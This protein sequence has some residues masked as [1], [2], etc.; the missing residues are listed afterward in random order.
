MR[1]RRAA[2]MALVAGCATGM[3]T[4][5]ED[6]LRRAAGPL[7]AAY[8]FI[9]EAPSPFFKGGAPLPAAGAGPVFAWTGPP[10]VFT[11]MGRRFSR[12]LDFTRSSPR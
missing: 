5:W 1:R 10:P 12:C 3:P 4:L 9:I 6:G 2:Q 7:K 11:R 8:E